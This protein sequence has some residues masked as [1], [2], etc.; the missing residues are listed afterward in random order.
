MNLEPLSSLRAW[1]WLG[2][3]NLRLKFSLPPGAYATT[4]LAELGEVRQAGG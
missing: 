2:P 4:V 1:D 3:A